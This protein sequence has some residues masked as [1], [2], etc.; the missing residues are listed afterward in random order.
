MHQS[1]PSLWDLNWEE[2]ISWNPRIFIDLR[3]QGLNLRREVAEQ[4]SLSVSISASSNQRSCFILN[5]HLRVLQKRSPTQKQRKSW[6][7]LYWWFWRCT[8]EK[9]G[10]LHVLPDG[11]HLILWAWIGSLLAQLF[12]AQHEWMSWTFAVL[13][14]SFLD[15]SLLISSF[16]FIFLPPKISS[17]KEESGPGETQRQ[18]DVYILFVCMYFL[19]TWI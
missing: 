2:S 5:F 14:L 16:L 9:K 19:N 17:W 18:V 4:M 12:C 15:P 13:F 3:P 8:W 11:G 7:L 10:Y 1:F 6:K